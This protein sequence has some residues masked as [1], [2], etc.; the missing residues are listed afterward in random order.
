MSKVLPNRPSYAESSMRH[1]Q[2]KGNTSSHPVVFDRLQELSDSDEVYEAIDILIAGADTTASTLT[3]G[4]FQ[5]LSWPSIHHK[6][7]KALEKVQ[8]DEHGALRLAELEKCDYLNA[9]V[10]ECIRIGMAVPGRLPRKVPEGDPFIVDGKVVPP[11]G[12]D[13]RVFNPDRCLT[14]DSNKFEQWIYTFCKGARMC[15]GQN[16]A[17]AEIILVLGY[18]FT[19]YHLHLLKDDAA[20]LRQ[21]DFTLSYP[22]GLQIS[23]TKK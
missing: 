21:D 18:L 1:W 8:S 3:T 10:K 20:P 6:L 17:P 23:F 11:G 5:I 12:P 16:V 7:L 9:V 22:G 14:P 2:K 19:R 13:A 15:I 4:I